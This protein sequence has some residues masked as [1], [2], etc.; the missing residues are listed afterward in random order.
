MLIFDLLNF[1]FT[2]RK[3]ILGVCNGK[4][5]VQLWIFTMRNLFFVILMVKNMG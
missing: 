4:N 5:F 1:D 3:V 2:M